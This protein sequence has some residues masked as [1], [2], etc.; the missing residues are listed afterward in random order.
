MVL[1]RQHPAG[2]IGIWLFGHLAVHLHHRGSLS[3]DRAASALINGRV[4]NQV[5]NSDR[6]SIMP[7]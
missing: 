5:T 2:V 7:L 1:L 3:R 6:F 4:T